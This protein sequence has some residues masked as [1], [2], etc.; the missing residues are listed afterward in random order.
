MIAIGP[1]LPLPPRLAG[2]F[3]PGIVDWILASDEP[4]A[5]FVARTRIVALP[6]HDAT[7][8]ADRTAS[9]ATKA[10]RDLVDTMPRWNADAYERRDSTRYLPNALL[11]L[12]DLGVRAGDFA[13]VDAAL[14][15]LLASRDR[16]GRFVRPGPVDAAASSGALC[17]AHAVL[18][19]VLRFG[20]RS[21]ERVE[22]ALEQALIDVRR[23]EIGRAWC[24]EARHRPRLPWRFSC[25]MCPHATVLA[26]R[27]MALLPER[28]RPPLA[29]DAARSL[30]AAWRRRAELR[31]SGFGHGYQFAAVK[32]PHLWYD[33]LAVIEAVGPYRTAWSGPSHDPEDRRSLAEVAAALVAANTDAE[34]RVVPQR[35][36]AGFRD[37]SWGRTGEPS[38]LA[39]AIV[40]AALEAISDLASEVAAV[41]AG[42]LSAGAPPPGEQRFVCAVLTEPR[43]LPSSSVIARLLQRQHIGTPWVRATPETFVSDVV[44]FPVID[45]RAP[46]L[47][48]ADRLGPDA[49]ERLVDALYR[50]R[51]LALFRCMRGGLHLVRSESL[52]VIAQVTGRAVRHHSAKFLGSRGVT[53]RHY[54]ILADR[55]LEA[56]RDG[57]LTVEEIRQAVPA[58]ADLA[59][60]VTHMS[61]EGLVIRDLPADGP[62]GHRT[63]YVRFADAFPSL[64]LDAVSEEE[65]VRELVRRYVR[66]YGPVTAADVAWWT[67]AGPRRTARVIAELGD[68][69][70]EVRVHGY[71]EHAFVHVADLDDLE[72][73]A[74]A[75]RPVAALLPA[76]DPLLAA[77]R[78]RGLHVPDEVRPHVFDQRGRCAPAIMVDGLVAGVWDLG[79]AD[80]LLLCAVAPIA[81]E[82]CAA[83]EVRARV[84]A[85]VFGAEA[86]VAWVSEAPDLASAGISETLHPL[87]KHAGRP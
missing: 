43:T 52:P 77:R 27:A 59:A 64:N 24:C 17:D 12:H 32:W 26:L 87:L 8:A 39:T 1:S 25:D 73:A 40:R 56:L 5:R 80:R 68:E 76:G 63:R 78:Q 48:V 3:G 58:H 46:Y 23:S 54:E 13:R 20:M 82:A 70:V 66:A 42:G 9:I 57:P 79:A 50:R 36:A 61:N 47:A 45:P 51:T 14:E 29:D 37:I 34:G 28:E 83:V 15:S 67:G 2:L 18:E 72:A 4:A 21:D 71:A 19:V 11:M 84:L 16:R 85:E 41:D 49:V 22:R 44:A 33:A 30:L 10:V 31:P 55:V 38:P 7:A 86:D 74:I 6:E 62:F 60:V 53:A 35:A 75:G 81:D 65:A 69:L